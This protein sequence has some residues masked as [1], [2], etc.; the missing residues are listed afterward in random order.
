[1]ETELEDERRKRQLY[2]AKEHRSPIGPRSPDR[3]VPQGGPSAEGR[4]GD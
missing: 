1:M 2:E 4:L 3:F